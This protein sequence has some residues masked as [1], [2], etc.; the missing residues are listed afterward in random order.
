MNKILLVQEGHRNTN[1]HTPR[2]PLF[3]CD[4]VLCIPQ[5]LLQIPLHRRHC[6]VSISTTKPHS[7]LC[8][9]LSYNINGFLSM[10]FSSTRT[11]KVYNIRMPHTPKIGLTTQDVQQTQY[12]HEYAQ[13][14]LNILLRHLVVVHFQDLF[15]R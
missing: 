10:F 12:A 4:A 8:Y 3:P 9:P 5:H 13:F 7:Y 6:A 14:P 11:H 1:I 15:Y 2:H